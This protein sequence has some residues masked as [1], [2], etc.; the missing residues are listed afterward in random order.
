MSSK[1][2]S[3]NVITLPINRRKTERLAIKDFLRIY[4]VID[5]NQMTQIHLV[6]VSSD[7]CSFQFPTIAGQKFA[8]HPDDLSV[9]LYF[10]NDTYLTISFNVK[11]SRSYVENDTQY[12]IYG[13][14]VDRSS[15]SFNVYLKFID[16]LKVYSENA[17]KDVGDTK[18]S[19]L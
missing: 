11:N 17:Q 1:N 10:S 12:T 19:Y 8:K 4:G 18:V 16:F 15:P 9:R 3:S 5:E 14:S 13:C 6:D 7:G 2:N